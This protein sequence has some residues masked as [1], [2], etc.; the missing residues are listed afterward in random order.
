MLPV[1]RE[2]NI[3]TKNL[4]CRECAWEGRAAEL[5]SG[6]IRITYTDIYLYAYRC[7]ECGSFDLASKGKLLSFKSRVASATHDNIQRDGDDEAAE[8]RVATEKLKRLW[9]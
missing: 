4:I 9:Q 3:Q 7:P 5:S 1:G 8:D 6:L 2:V